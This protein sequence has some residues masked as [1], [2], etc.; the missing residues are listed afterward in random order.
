MKFQ[1]PQ[2][3]EIEDKI[4]GPLSFKEFIYLLGGGGL[5]F[6]IYRFSPS[7]I[8]TIL[9]VLPIGAFSIALAFYRPNNKPFIE[10]VQS[11]LVYFSGSKL[12]LW[13]KKEA[14]I[15]NLVRNIE[16]NDNPLISL[17]NSSQ[18][19]LSDISFSLTA[20]AKKS[21]KEKSSLNLKI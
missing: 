7:L 18:N 13:K 9:L 15:E 14:T 12:Y 10:M 4:F 5:C 6:L 2:F 3:I 20:G 11:A 21:S 8:L 17:P 1:V 19:S 16:R